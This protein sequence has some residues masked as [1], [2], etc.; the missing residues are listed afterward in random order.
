V[1][2]TPD[3]SII[4]P[5]FNEEAMLERLLPYLLRL[6]GNHEILIVDG[7]STDQSQA[8]VGRF[9]NIRLLSAPDRGRAAQMN[10]GSHHALAPVL[11][12]L[13]AD[14]VPPPDAVDR[15][16][17]A[18]RQPG[19]VAGSFCLK[20]DRSEWYFRWLGKGSS[21]NFGWSTFGDQGLFLTTELFRQVG[22]FPAWPI[23]EDVELVK[24]L[25]RRGRFVKLSPCVCTSARRYDR[26]GFW[27]QLV[28]DVFLYV[29]FQ[30]G[31]SPGRIKVW[32][33]R[34]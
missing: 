31:V 14:T 29:S 20:F 25:R 28:L 34:G 11:F 3:V 33:E 23:L 15:V 27:R 17:S 9:P 2:E 4:L 22:G 1:K 24:R 6:S 12:F 30:L 18:L 26:R 32:S 10:W 5:V 13:H 8:L 16:L 19:V 7:G 21:L